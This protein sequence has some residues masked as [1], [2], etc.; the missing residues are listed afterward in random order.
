MASHKRHLLSVTLKPDL[1]LAAKSAAAVRD[2]PVTAWVR[3]LICRELH[4]TT[5]PTP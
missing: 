2:I 4:P 3:E 1:Y 5:P